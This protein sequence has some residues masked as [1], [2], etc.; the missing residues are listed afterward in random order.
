MANVLVVTSNHPP[1]IRAALEDRQR[2]VNGGGTVNRLFLLGT[3]DP[4]F[5]MRGLQA[6]V[7]MGEVEIRPV[8][9]T[10]DSFCRLLGKVL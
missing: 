4:T 1:K 9:N 10:G 6:L 7:R 5:G 2:Q 3:S 8:G